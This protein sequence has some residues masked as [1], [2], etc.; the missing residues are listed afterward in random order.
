[1]IDE[2]KPEFKIFD[3][4]VQGGSKQKYGNAR[5][6]AVNYVAPGVNICILLM[7]L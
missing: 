7:S 1:M 2:E 5:S 6:W 4:P 3:C